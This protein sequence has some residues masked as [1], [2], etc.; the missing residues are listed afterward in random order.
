LCNSKGSPTSKE[1]NGL[2]GNPTLEGVNGFKESMT[3]E[4]VSGFRRSLNS[5]GVNRVKGRVN[6]LEGV[7]LQFHMEEQHLPIMSG[8]CHRWRWVGR[9]LKR[10]RLIGERCLPRR[11]HV[12]KQDFL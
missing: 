8:R 10:R 2:R 11:D 1:A 5:K 9:K 4:G 12:R 3:S 6:H 7:Y